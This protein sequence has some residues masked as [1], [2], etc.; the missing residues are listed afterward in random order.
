MRRLFPA[1]L[2]ALAAVLPVAAGS[3]RA[4]AA[5]GPTPV[6]PSPSATPPEVLRQGPPPPPPA[7][8]VRWSGLLAGRWRAFFTTRPMAAEGAA[9]PALDA[10]VADLAASS[11]GDLLQKVNGRRVPTAAGPVTLRTN[12]HAAVLRFHQLGPG[13]R[14]LHAVTQPVAIYILLVLAMAGIAFELTQSGIGVAGIAGL[15]AAGLAVYG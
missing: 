1:L 8:S 7:T 6:D 2:L 13:R 11:I 10:R 9:Q 5:P 3:A 12:P 4:L 15:V 14:I